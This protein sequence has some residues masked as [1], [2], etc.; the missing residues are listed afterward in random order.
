MVKTSKSKKSLPPKNR[1]FLK[2][3]TSSKEVFEG[4]ATIKEELVEETDEIVPEQAQGND[5]E[6]HTYFARIS[7]KVCHST[8]SARSTFL[9]HYVAVHL[10][11]V[12]KKPTKYIHYLL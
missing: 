2:T 4:V 9:A 10:Q 12:N 6:D 5:Q 8:Y 7:C 3:S 1:P 11:Q